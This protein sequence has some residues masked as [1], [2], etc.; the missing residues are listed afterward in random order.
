VQ[1][2]EQ[3]GHN[4]RHDYYCARCHHALGNIRASVPPATSI[5]DDSRCARHEVKNEA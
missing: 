4:Q 5:V 1:V 3:Y 2:T